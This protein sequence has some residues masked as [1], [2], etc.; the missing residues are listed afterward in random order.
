MKKFFFAA[1]IILHG[2]S[3]MAQKINDPN[4]EVREAKNFHGISVGHAFD[5]YLNQSNEEAV[6]VSAASDKDREHIKVEVNDGIL[7]IGLDKGW[8]W[9]GGNKKLKAYIS[10][11]KI[12]KLSISGACDVVVAGVIKTADLTIRQSGASDFN[13]KIDVDKLTVDLS[14]ASDMT[15]SGK[16]SNLDIDASGASAF[17]GFEL[18]T[19]SCNAEASGA[20]DIKITVS[21]EISAQASGASDV[22]YK[23]GAAIREIK[24]SGSSSVSR[25]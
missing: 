1:A 15:I 12:D 13:G 6:A 21:K 24:S 10:F 20:S 5:V 9:N 17:K 8:K 11:K 16:A 19:E 2:S 23:G 18:M 14:G 3:V 4:A 7:Y 25:G 22:R